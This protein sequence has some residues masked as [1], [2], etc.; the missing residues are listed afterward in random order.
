MLKRRELEVSRR[1]WSSR[2]KQ[3][4]SLFIFGPS[5]ICSNFVTSWLNFLK[6]RV[7][8]CAALQTKRTSRAGYLPVLEGFFLHNISKIKPRTY[9]TKTYG[10]TAQTEEVKSQH[11]KD[12]IA[13]ILC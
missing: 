11:W 5:F 2:R 8:Q 4:I 6:P 3:A 7:I 10:V 12:E 9:R 1:Y 13:Y